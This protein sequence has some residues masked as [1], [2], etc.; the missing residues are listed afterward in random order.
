MTPTLMRKRKNE[1]F[2]LLEV[3]ICMGIIVVALMAVFRLQGQNLVLQTEAQ[4]I[5][6][7]R[8]LAQDRFS[9]IQIEEPVLV[10]RKVGDFGEAFPHFK[11]EE[12]VEPTGDMN[13]LYKVSVRILLEQ[14]GAL[15][16]FTFETFFL[17]AAS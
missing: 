1:G 15:K 11:Y 16:D 4:F 14:E 10:G 17:R 7:A 13:G 9:R 6:L 5:T 8:Y 2:T 3:L 12:E